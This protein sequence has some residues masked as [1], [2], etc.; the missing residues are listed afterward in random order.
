MLSSRKSEQLGNQRVSTIE[1]SKERSN[2]QR[3]HQIRKEIPIETSEGSKQI[4][5]H[6]RRFNDIGCQRPIHD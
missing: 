2:A 6:L 4:K 1:K 3:D 5:N